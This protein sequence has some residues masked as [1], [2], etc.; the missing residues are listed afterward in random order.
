LAACVL[1]MAAAL[2]AL[3]LTPGLTVLAAFTLPLGVAGTSCVAPL[4]V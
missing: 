1:G 3:G 4:A 2:L